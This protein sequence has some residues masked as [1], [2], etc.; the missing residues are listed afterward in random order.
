MVR[1]NSVLETR[2]TPQITLIQVAKNHQEIVSLLQL[3]VVWL[4][5]RELK[6]LGLLHQG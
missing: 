4:V 5:G 3:Q 6:D 2:G 1:T